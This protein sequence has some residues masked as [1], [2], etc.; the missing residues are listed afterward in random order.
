M[1]IGATFLR[2][3]CLVAV[4]RGL[5]LDTAF[6]LSQPTTGLSATGKAACLR[7]KINVT[8]SAT[9]TKLLVKSPTGQPDLTQTIVDMATVGVDYAAMVNGGPRQVFGTYHLYVELC[10]PADPVA[11]RKV[12]T[13]QFLNHGGTLDH[14]YWD[15]A[16]GYSYV[17]AAAAAGYA[18]FNY[19]RL[20][21][22]LSDHPDPNQVVQAALQREI[23]HQIV[24]VLRKAK[25]GKNRIKNVVG[26]GHSAGSALIIATVGK[27]PADFDAL[28]FTGISASVQGVMIAQ[29]AFNL[30][31]ASLDPSCRFNGLDKGY[32]TQGAVAQDFQF[33]F[34]HYPDFD[35]KIFRKQF[36]TRQTTVFGELLT[37]SSVVAPQPAYTGPV[38]VVL[39]QE[40]YVF[41]QA[42]CSY[43][44]D[45]AQ[46]FVNALFPASRSKSTFLQPKSG[47]LMAQH[48]TARDGFEHSLQFLQSNAL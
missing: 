13:L 4:A 27:Y 10:V 7:G 14:T 24:G 41:C 21:Y 20:G 16:A 46:T 43:P 9:N 5:Q 23:A 29:F 44:T 2:L 26:V 42:N 18:T 45:Q 36:D 48:Y 47:H 17:D 40:D 12:Q 34:Y 38:D 11:A 33:P 32:L 3:A 31:P 39:G 1:G 8:A 6:V 25:I 15:F 19:D 22:G 30:V 28:I 35:P 37:F